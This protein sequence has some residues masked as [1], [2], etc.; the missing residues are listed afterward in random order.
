MKP[1]WTGPGSF[2]AR[3]LRGVGRNPAVVLGL[4]PNSLSTIRALAR[5]GVPVVAIGP[6]P[7]GPS[8]L[9]GWMA[10]RTRLAHRITVAREAWPAALPAILAACAPAW[11]GRAVILPSGD[12][13]VTELLAHRSELDDV[14]AVALPDAG[15]AAT[16]A[17]KVAFSRFAEA[18]GVA[19]PVT[20]VGCTGA[21]LAVRAPALRYPCIVKPDQRDTVWDRRFSNQKVLEAGDPAALVAAFELAGETHASLVVQEVVP[22]GDEL[23]SFSHVYVGRDGRELALWTGHKVRQLPIHFGT[24]T[25][26]RT[27]WDPEVA[28]ATRRL[29]QDTGYV[30]YASVEFKRDP[31]DG[32]PRA[33]EVTV[34]RTWYPH[35]LGVAAGV[36]IPVVWYRD[37]LGEE[38][39]P[40]PPQ[41]DGV[42]WFDEVRDLYAAMDYGAAGELT[43]RQW[44][45]SLRGARSYAHFAWDDP[46][47]GVFVVART[48][49]AAGAALRRSVTRPVARARAPR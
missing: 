18:R 30:G 21:E 14:Y 13:E 12:A 31:R 20:L 15:L 28:A 19:A 7:L 16:L 37:A 24:S 35:G 40:Q 27:R 22:G 47:P 43:F 3:P 23:L 29:L 10:V 4:N 49:L 2:D 1:T 5:A 42:L 26:A 34:G 41:R 44:R 25:L 33:L 8:D 39:P 11:D 46:L 36:N 17:D 48:L 38:P 32:V 45:E 6:V 9:H